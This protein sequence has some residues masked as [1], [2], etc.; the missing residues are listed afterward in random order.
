VVA[1]FLAGIAWML[2]MTKF[3]VSYAYPFMSL[4]YVL[5]FVASVLLFQEAFT[6]AKLAGTAFVV[7]GI[8]IMARG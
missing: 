5:V 7:A 8:L 3:E 4:N 1:T 6:G 2:A